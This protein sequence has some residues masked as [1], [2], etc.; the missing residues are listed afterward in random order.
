MIF[1]ESLLL[2]TACKT[3]VLAGMLG[4]GH[5]AAGQAEQAV[6]RAIDRQAETV[7]SSIK[8]RLEA[9]ASEAMAERT[10][11]QATDSALQ[12]VEKAVSNQAESVQDQTLDRVGQQVEEIQEQVVENTQSGIDRALEQS[13]ENAQQSIVENAVN[14][15]EQV[16][17]RATGSARRGIERA[18]E[19]AGDVAQGLNNAAH[20]VE[21][22]NQTVPGLPDQLP[23][24]DS[25]GNELFVEITVENNHRAIAS[26]WLMILNTEQRDRLAEAAPGIMP[27]LID[28]QE[29]SATGSQILV[30]SLPP[31][32]DNRNA[33]ESMLTP[34][35]ASLIDRN[36]VYEAQA[37]ELPRPA[38]SGQSGEVV[39]QSPV[40]LGVIDSAANLEHPAFGEVVS[41]NGLHE[42]RFLDENIQQ[43]RM[44]GT[45]ILSRIV[46]RGPSLVPLLPQGD[47]YSAAVVYSRNESHQ[48]ATALHLLEALDWF[49]AQEDIRVV[50]IS[51]AGPPN[52]LLQRQ[53]EQTHSMG[54]FL[55]AAAGNSGPHASPRYPA[56]YEE[57]ISVTATDSDQRVYPLANRGYVDFAAEG[58]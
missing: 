9:Q 27:Y 55:V 48:G 15:A 25:E 40:S 42:K 5:L 28:S 2:K 41:R 12:S 29:L 14:N 43:S 34:E 51:L 31:D 4:F 19:R 32:I 13:S 49:L 6:E 8:E 7:V 47:I 52:R 16:Q 33:V 18:M 3:I 20:M 36:H 38:T 56:A 22:E 50:N 57:V 45:A 30:F 39:C 21:R 53:V 1:R 11:E 54:L 23:I 58:V 26:E 44:H 35:Y 17:E 46:G 37:E 24:R 10:A